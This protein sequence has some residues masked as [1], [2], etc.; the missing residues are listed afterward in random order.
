MS[1]GAGNGPHIG[2][3]HRAFTGKCFENNIRKPVTVTAGVRDR[4]NND[5]VGVRVCLRKLS[6]GFPSTESDVVG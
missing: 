4:R 6:V 1:D 5:D 3:N 2:G